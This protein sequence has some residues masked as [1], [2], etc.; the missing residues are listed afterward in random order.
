MQ[1]NKPVL[2][3]QPGF[4]GDILFCIKIAAVWAARGHRVI[5]PVEPRFSDISAALELPPGV[6][7]PLASEA[8]AFRD[9]YL[10]FL[11]ATDEA[12]AA[13]NFNFH[14]GPIELQDL[15]VLPLASSWWTAIHDTM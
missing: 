5:F 15:I 11:R 14:Q 8:F 6:E 2:I 9:A 13:G 1:A 10:W 3:I 7:M 12:A 4:A